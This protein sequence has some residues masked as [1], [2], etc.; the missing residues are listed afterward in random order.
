ML[1]KV[2]SHPLGETCT[3]FRYPKVIKW[4]V[5]R[6]YGMGFAARTAVKIDFSSKCKRSFAS[7]STSCSRC[8]RSLRF[9]GTKPSSYPTPSSSSAFDLVHCHAF[10]YIYSIH[11]H[12][13]L[14][15][16]LG[17][18]IHLC[19]L[20]AFFQPKNKLPVRV[21]SDS[22]IFKLLFLFRRTFQRSLYHT[23]KNLINIIHIIR[24]EIKSQKII[25]K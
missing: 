9:R 11:V 22:S 25:S 3:D 21:L 4:S 24:I 17:I 2:L 6:K 12:E 1:M 15:Y 13:H 16:S 10:K 23:I 19:I 7:C 14:V 8:E 5:Y 18:S 20:W